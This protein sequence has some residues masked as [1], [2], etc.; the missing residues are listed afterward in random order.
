MEVSQV[1]LK[2]YFFFSQFSEIDSLQFM[3]VFFS[4]KKKSFIFML[5][6]NDIYGI[7][8]VGNW[9]S[10]Y[11]KYKRAI[12]DNWLFEIRNQRWKIIGIIFRQYSIILLYVGRRGAVSIETFIHQAVWY[13]A[14]GWGEK[15]AINFLA[16][17]ITPMSRRR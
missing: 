14:S 12:K 4:K 2:C 6:K 11:E 16:A 1:L 9:T 10:V 5:F 8:N 7:I 3:D 15:L 13:C 17:R